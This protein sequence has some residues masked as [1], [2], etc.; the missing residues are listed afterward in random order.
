[1]GTN[2]GLKGDHCNFNKIVFL[3]QVFHCD[4]SMCSCV[5]S[6]F[7][8]YLFSKGDTGRWT[9]S[10]LSYETEDKWKDSMWKWYL[11]K[12]YSYR[13]SCKVVKI[14]SLRQQTL[15][16]L[17]PE[18][19]V[20]FPLSPKVLKTVFTLDSWVCHYLL[21]RSL[22]VI[23]LMKMH[24]FVYIWYLWKRTVLRAWKLNCWTYISWGCEGFW[25]SKDPKHHMTSGNIT[26]DAP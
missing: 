13:Y 19:S 18:I 21:S 15:N 16:L 22:D 24:I 25:C 14:I 11:C 2:S 6:L 3:L 7:M 1:M 26:D 9:L 23:C 20:L 8:K 4:E 17:N 5:S 10:L 12:S